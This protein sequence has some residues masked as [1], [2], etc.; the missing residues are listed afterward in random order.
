MKTKNITQDEKIMAADL[1]VYAIDVYEEEVK[2]ESLVELAK[3]GIAMMAYAT[4]S[5]SVFTMHDTCDVMALIE[6]AQTK[7]A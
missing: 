4:G 3:R 1:I 5:Q 7:A 6:S 2:T